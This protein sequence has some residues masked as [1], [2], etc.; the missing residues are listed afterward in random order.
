VLAGVGPEIEAPISRENLASRESSSHLPAMSDTLPRLAQAL[1]GRYAPERELGAGGMATVYLAHDVR[2]DRQVALKVLRPELA[3]VIGA[4]R[5]LAEIKTT[6]NL[7]HPHILP[8]FDS[9]AVE[10]TVFY[11]MPFVEGESL[12]ERLTRERQLPVTEAVRIATEVAAALDYAHRHGVIHRDIKPENILLHDGS[13]LVADFGIALALSRTDGGTR[14][15]ET[16]L[17][18]GTP[19]YMSP[20]QA[21]GE[22][23]VDARTDVYALACVLYEMLTGD[24]PFSASSAQAVVAKVLT[25]RPAPVRA[26]RDTVP[27][28]VDAAVLT[29]LAKLPADRFSSAAD[30]AEALAS[31]GPTAR[32]TAPVAGSGSATASD[33][34][35]SRRPRAS[36]LPTAVA[37]IVLAAAAGWAARQ[38]TTRSAPAAPPV[39]FTLK[40]GDPVIDDQFVALSP[41]GR[42]VIQTLTDSAGVR[43]VVARDLGTTETVQIPG[44]E[45][46]QFASYSADGRWI[47]FRKNNGLWKVPAEGGA[48]ARITEAPNNDVGEGWMADGSVL[49]TF[50]D[51]GIGRIPPSGGDGIRLT[52]IDTTRHEFAHWS[53][54]V[55]PGGHAFIFANYATPVERARIEAYEFG[56]GRRTVLVENAIFPRYS[57]GRLFFVRGGALWAVGFDP[58]KLRVKGEPVP[59]QD[60]VAWLPSNGEAGYD[61]SPDGTLV[62]ARASRWKVEGHVVWVDRHG[63]ETPAIPEAGS[64]SEPRLSPDGRWIAL[65]GHE[66]KVDL[67]LYDVRREVLNQLTHAPGSAFDAIWMPDGRR[68]VYVFEDPV[69]D[70]HLLTIDAS[71]PD[72][73]ILATPNDKYPGSVSPDGRLLA[74]TS[75]AGAWDVEIKT[76]SDTMAPSTL[77]SASGERSDPAFSGDGR[78]I[79]YE[80]V[81]NARSEVYFTAVDGAGGRYL[82]SAGGGTEPLWT[83]GGRE[84]VY[85]RGDAMMAARVTPTT[86]EV[87]SPEV[88]FRVK[89]PAPGVAR[90][91][92]YDVTS[93]GSRF[94]MVKPLERPGLQPL[95]VVVNW[96]ATLDAKGNR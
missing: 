48:A 40:L 86:G 41:D 82:V 15:T 79:A 34:G 44:T 57:G 12:R 8:L 28:H 62:F 17:S 11:V 72:R 21:M 59:V 80:E 37:L 91:R 77:G 83:K 14:L 32:R 73:T 36:S 68:L 96:V 38:V 4:E 22:R 29:A 89:S 3:A 18:L 60:D 54:V 94:L 53:P 64:W 50:I 84:I 26:A 30:F 69:Y 70:L 81:T 85:R 27:E 52:Q 35:R 74:F 39:R 46:A 75:A 92:S 1:E 90:Y 33:R 20:E 56:S 78:W 24:P 2:H 49:M 95:E 65:T 7:Q 19:F 6:A 25:E 51:G 45:D 31:P 66:P 87:G 9:G 13:A 88:L 93:D 23:T 61:V 43:H 71:A 47:S 76:L 58:V 42:R 67:W 5:F 55:L 16:G 10:G 63:A